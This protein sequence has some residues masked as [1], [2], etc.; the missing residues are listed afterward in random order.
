MPKI[1]LIEEK[2][3]C[4]GLL[5]LLQWLQESQSSRQK[6]VVDHPHQAV[7]HVCHPQVVFLSQLFKH[8]L[9]F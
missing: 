8:Q 6:A 2:R 1:E 5:L 9:R 4:T 7:Y 3:L